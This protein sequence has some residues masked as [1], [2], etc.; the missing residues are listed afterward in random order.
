MGDATGPDS[1]TRPAARALRPMS[2]GGPPAEGVLWCPF[3]LAVDTIGALLNGELADHPVYDGFELQWFDD[4]THG[5]GVLAFLSRCADG[6]VDYYLQRG[7]RVDPDG[8]AIGAGLG[9]WGEAD[10]DVA[11]LEVT[12]EGVVADVRFTDME[13]R[14]VEVSVDDRSAGP[15]RTTDLLAPVSSGIEDPVSLMLVQLHGFDLLRRSDIAPQVRI[16]GEPVSTGVLPGGLL[17]RRHLVK[18]AAPLTVATLCRA[19]SG[20]LTPVDV[21][22]PGDVVLDAA[23]TGVLGCVARHDGAGAI[24]ALHPPFPALSSLGDG[25]QRTGSWLVDVDDAPVVGGTWSARRQ[26]DEV[27]LTLEVTRGW[28]PPPGQPLLVRLVT[29]VV[30]VFRTWP[31][32]YRWSAQVLLDRGTAVMV[33][34]WA[35]TGKDRGAGYGRLTRSRRARRSRG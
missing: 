30:P 24:L 10:F 11:L 13:G 12:P 20:P 19:R 6:R 21:D 26:S 35:R 25:E 31:T 7:L 33:S 2:T 4:P 28:E 32:T 23:G 34:S 17:H 9:R 14:V 22:D 8:Y 5:R 16:D 29:R 27:A 1:S 18:A 3:D 15:R